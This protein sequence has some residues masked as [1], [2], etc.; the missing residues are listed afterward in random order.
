MK[1][2]VLRHGPPTV[3]NP[4]FL[5]GARARGF[6]A[7]DFRVLGRIVIYWVLTVPFA[8]LSSMLLYIF[9]KWLFY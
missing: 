9:L 7:V 8:A 1:T 3:F 6:G 2:V 5:G 4:S